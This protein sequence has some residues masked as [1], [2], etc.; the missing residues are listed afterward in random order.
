MW[1]DRLWCL[2]L[3]GAI[4]KALSRVVGEKELFAVSL[5][6]ALCFSIFIAFGGHSSL[7]T[8]TAFLCMLIV[9]L[10]KLYTWVRKRDSGATKK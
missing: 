10:V 3:P 4:L 6:F 5:F 2:P 9:T 1:W 8:E 7:I